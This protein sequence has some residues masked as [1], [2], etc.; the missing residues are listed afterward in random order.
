MAE[1]IPMFAMPNVQ[2][3][4]PIEVDGMAIVSCFDPRIKALEQRAVFP[5]WAA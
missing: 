5:R 3:Q 1:W 2:V 4:D